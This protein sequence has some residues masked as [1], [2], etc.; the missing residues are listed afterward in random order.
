MD[1]RVVDL[2]DL[3]RYPLEVRFFELN[4]MVLPYLDF[5]VVFWLDLIMDLNLVRIDQSSTRKLPM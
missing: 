4:N 2:S 3:P 5:C 1:R